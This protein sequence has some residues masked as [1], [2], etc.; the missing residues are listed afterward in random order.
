[1]KRSEVREFI[2]S[3][4]ELL[5]P[6]TQFNNGR[7]SEFKS[8][9]DKTFPYIWLET[10]Q[11]STSIPNEG[12][13]PIDDWTISIHVAKQ[14]TLDSIPVQYEQIVDECDEIAQKLINK[15]NNI[16]SGYQ[17]VKL[18]GITRVP[19]YKIGAEPMTGVILGFTLNAP[20]TTN[21]C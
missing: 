13:A 15:F 3:G 18:S 8:E 11:P 21:L 17:L 20:D 9:S 16:V 7:L 5:S 4:V 14:D 6:S 1:M 10:L 2:R 19:F 12:N